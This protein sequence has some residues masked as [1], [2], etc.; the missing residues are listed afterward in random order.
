MICK[1]CGQ[2][3]ITFRNVQLQKIHEIK[4][5]NS[6]DKEYIEFDSSFDS[7]SDTCAS[8]ECKS[9]RNSL[10]AQVGVLENQIRIIKKMMFKNIF[11]SKREMI[12]FISDVW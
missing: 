11:K 2:S 9:D 6:I 4:Q 12:E 1:F 7:F 5:R 3:K 10:K 8:E